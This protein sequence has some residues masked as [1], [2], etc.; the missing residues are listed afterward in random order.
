MREES[1][2]RKEGVT[3][4]SGMGLKDASNSS[5]KEIGSGI[6]REGNREE[7]GKNIESKSNDKENKRAIEREIND[8]LVPLCAGDIFKFE[9]FISPYIVRKKPPLYVHRWSYA[10]EQI[11]EVVYDLETTGLS[12][13]FCEITQTAAT[14]FDG[15]TTSDRYLLPKGVI[16]VDASSE[17]GL[18]VQ[19]FD[20][21]L[22]LVKDGK[23][24]TTVSLE[25]ALFSFIQF[26]KGFCSQQR[27]R[28]CYL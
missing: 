16:S 23:I 8:A 4:E 5:D 27:K 3:Y 10:D 7:G 22:H 13:N 21:K 26:L 28:F 18:S 1:K 9:E 19:E 12:T 2:C 14:T 24:L 20:G 11:I 25:E 15:T 17:T 6:E